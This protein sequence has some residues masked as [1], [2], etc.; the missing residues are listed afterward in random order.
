MGGRGD[1][2]GSEAEI[3]NTNIHAHVGVAYAS[4]SAIISLLALF[5]SFCK[6]PLRPLGQSEP[7]SETVNPPSTSDTVGPIHQP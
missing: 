6:T 3:A 7:V 1:R 5:Q 4:P 2:K